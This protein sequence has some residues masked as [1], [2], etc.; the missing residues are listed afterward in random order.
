[1]ND[2][3]LVLWRR[4]F[5]DLDP[6][7]PANAE[8]V[9]AARPVRL[10]P[11]QTLFRPGSSCQNYALVTSGRIRVQLLAASGRE[12]LLYQ[13]G[14]GDACVLTTACLLGQRP[15]PAEG[16]TET[17][18]HAFVIDH[19]TFQSTLE[20]SE[21]FRRF[22]FEKLSQRLT[23]VINRMETVAFTGVEPRLARRLLESPERRLTIT[24]QALATELGCAREVISRHLKRFE[25]A[26]WIRLT[27]GGIEILVPAALEHVSKA[28]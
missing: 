12:V 27:R 3:E 15:Y 2:T 17:E 1:M 21:P 19:G 11:N 20:S 25:R 6:A 23:E 5:P 16:F 24:H 22:V 7:D 8:L 18:V 13:V 4:H 28:V 14:P 9:A 10:P 26:G